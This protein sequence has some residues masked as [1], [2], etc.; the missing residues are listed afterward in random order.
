MIYGAEVSGFGFSRV[1][2]GLFLVYVALV[3]VGCMPA[4]LFGCDC[5]ICYLL[6]TC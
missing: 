6:F 4:S 2:G 5:R 3:V 1:F